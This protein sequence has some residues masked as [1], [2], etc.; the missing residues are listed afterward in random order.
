MSMFSDTPLL[1]INFE[2]KPLLAP[3]ID[4]PHILI[5]GGGIIGMSTAWTL[6]DS[7]FKVTVLAQQ[8]ASR[9]GVRLTS[10]IAGALW[11]YPPAVCGHTSDATAL[12]SSKRWAMISYHVY[13]YMAANPV[14]RERYSVQ[15]RE[16]VF[17]FDKR[18]QEDPAQLH[19]MREME[20][21]GIAGFRHDISVMHELGLD[22]TRW[23]DAYEV[24]SPLIDTDL[25]LWRITKLVEYKG[26]KLVVGSITGDLLAQEQALLMEHRADAIV[27]ASGLGAYTLANDDQVYPLRG[28]VLR[29]L[30]DGEKFEK[31]KKALVV[32]A[33]ANGHVKSDFI[34]IVPRN[35]NILY[36]GGFSEPD[37]VDRIDEDHENVQKVIRD[38]QEFLP[39]LDLSHRDPAYPLAQGLRPARIGDLRV[40]RELRPPVGGAGPLHSRIVHCY[41]HAGAGWSLAFGSALEVKTLVEDAL[42]QLPPDAMHHAASSAVSHATVS[43]LENHGALK[44]P[45]MDAVRAEAVQK[46]LAE[47]IEFHD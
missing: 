37:Q 10:Q 42:E 8:F 17:F 23:V 14:L 33:T 6:L 2:R 4:A 18:V 29:L 25:A 36:V 12:E 38:A 27:N 35:E 16:T 1:H 13:K 9:D 39:D 45:T 30:N 32:S 20:R 28:A 46:W 40:E 34:F 15:M 3:A 7:G 26:A 5:I 21:S 31:I 44:K 41:G 22:E 43:H 47:P 11:E 19:K 24:L